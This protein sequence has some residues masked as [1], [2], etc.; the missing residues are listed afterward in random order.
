MVD[1]LLEAQHLATR[2]RRARLERGLSL[3][4][5]AA[6]IGVTKETLSDLERAR[7]QPHPPTLAKI[8][9]GYGV[10]ISDLLGPMVEEDPVLLGKGEAPEEA[11]P[12]EAGD[13]ERIID[14]GPAEFHRKLSEAPS[15]KDLLDLYHRVDAERVATELAFR[16]DEDNDRALKDHERAL[17]YYMMAVLSLNIRGVTPPDPEQLATR[18]RELEALRK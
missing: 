9:A 4:G 2:L 1:V 12:A 11:G 6:E 8:A 18:V 15:N 3:R 13:E 14:M 7:R 10:E 17:R 16:D 5:A